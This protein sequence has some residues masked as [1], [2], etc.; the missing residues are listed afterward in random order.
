MANAIVLVY[1]VFLFAD[2]VIVLI[3]VS[4]DEVNL[5]NTFLL[6]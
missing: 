2:V 1:H 5:K 4:V 3:F 6:W